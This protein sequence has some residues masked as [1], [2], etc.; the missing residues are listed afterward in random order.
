MEAGCAFPVA[1]RGAIFRGS[2]RRV[3]SVW[4]LRKRDGYPAH[5][6]VCVLCVCV[7]CVCVFDRVCV[8]R[9]CV[10]VCCVCV[11]CVCV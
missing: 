5:V 2:K 9:V 7:F 3:F 1:K 11:L 4:R 8:Y 6:C 10:C